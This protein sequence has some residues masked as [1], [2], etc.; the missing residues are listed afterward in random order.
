MLVIMVILL[1]TGQ[2]ISL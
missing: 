1:C 2:K